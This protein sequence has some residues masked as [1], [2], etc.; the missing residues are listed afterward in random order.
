L[1]ATVGYT[2]MYLSNVARAPSQV[3]LSLNPTQFNGGVL[4]GEPRPAF[5]FHTSDIWLQGFNLGVEYKY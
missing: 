3:D 5:A 2:F 4:D 1:R